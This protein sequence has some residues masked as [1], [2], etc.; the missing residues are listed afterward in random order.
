M[1]EL[2]DRLWADYAAITP[3]AARIHALLRGR[4]ETVRND[5]IALRA[6]DLPGVDIDALDRAFVA[7]G[8]RAAD[9]YEFPDKHL[10]AYHYEHAEPGRPKLFISA[11]DVGALSEEAAA[12]VR[13]L[14]AQLPPGASASPWF[15]VSGRRW[16]VDFAAVERLRAE[17]EY[18]AWLAVFGFRANHFTVDVNALTTF[19]SLEELDRFLQDNGFRMN[20]SGGLIKGTPAQLLEQ[21]STL[22]DEVEVELADGPHRLPSCYYEFARRYPGPDG[23][24]FQG[25]VPTSATRIFESTDRQS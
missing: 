17:S 8:Y 3:Q 13:G 15:A 21:S 18:A 6:F 12:I 7:G 22:A 19:A 4:G 10:H 14:V 20:E 5:H 24:L 16:Q 11:L 23:R 9:S 25:F 2:F 1:Q